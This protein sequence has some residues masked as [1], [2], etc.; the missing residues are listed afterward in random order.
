MR[1]ATCARS[2]STRWRASYAQSAPSRHQGH[3]RQAGALHRLH[4][5]TSTPCRTVIPSCISFA[6]TVALPVGFPSMAVRTT[7]RLCRPL[8][9]HRKRYCIAGPSGTSPQRACRFV[10]LWRAFRHTTARSYQGTLPEYRGSAAAGPA[11]PA[12]LFLPIPRN[13]KILHTPRRIR[14]DRPF[15]AD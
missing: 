14:G 3:P 6:T 11:A 10:Y 12:W 2:F 15:A 8:S 13:L 1:R 4:S 9:Y 7:Q 5:L